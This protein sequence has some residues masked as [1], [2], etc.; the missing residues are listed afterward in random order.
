MGEAI[1]TILVFFGVIAVTV[2]VFGI[3]LIVT[4]VR[5]IARAIGG[6]SCMSRPDALPAPPRSIAR[7][8]LSVRCRRSGCG[9][10]N[11]AGAKFCRRC[12]AELAETQSVSVRRVAMW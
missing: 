3:W 11:P 5:M 6:G 9:A 10:D 1:F 4:V 7:E 12:G 2:V 8:L